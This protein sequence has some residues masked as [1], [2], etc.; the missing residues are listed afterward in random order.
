L[1]TLINTVPVPPEPLKIDSHFR[2]GVQFAWD[3]TSLK[4][5]QTCQ[6]YYKYKMIDC[7]EAPTKSPHLLFGGWYATALEHFYKHRALGMEYEEAVESVVMEAMISTWEYKHDTD[8]APILDEAGNHVGEGW[9]SF[10]TNKTRENLIRTIIWYLEFFKGES[11]DTV[12]LAN[13]KPAVEHSFTLAVD[14]GIILSGHLDRL[15]DYSGDYYI[16]DQKTTG[17]TITPRFFEGFDPDT[18]MSLYSFAGKAIFDIPIKG[19]IIDGAQ[20]AVGFSRFE[21]GY[22]FRT[23]DQLNEWY[24]DVLSDIERTQENT[25]N[26]HFPKNPAACGNYGGCEFR[27]IC[28]KSPGV[29]NIFL[30]GAFV[31]RKQWNPLERR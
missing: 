12:I 28:S 17:S 26:N 4:W 16:M 11:L 8:G 13:G 15:V 5:A 19:V 9:K 3:S 31:K 21:R 20:I 6:Q 23:E 30:N 14:N 25:R 22:S 18:Q 10:D 29:R 2:D 7:W 27:S 24:E 1:T